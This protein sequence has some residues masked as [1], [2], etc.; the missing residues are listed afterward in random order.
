MNVKE[1]IGDFFLDISKLIFGGI[2]L[3]SIVNEPINKWVIY[4][5]GLFFSL[6]L[7]LLGFALIDNSKKKEVKL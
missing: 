7:M 6:L 4:S 2:I 3:S 1:K 5:L